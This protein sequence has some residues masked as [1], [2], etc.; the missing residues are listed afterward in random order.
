MAEFRFEVLIKEA[1]RQM[2]GKDLPEG[3][4]DWV[5]VMNCIAWN[6][7]FPGCL[8]VCYEIAR[9]NNVP[10]KEEEIKEIAEFQTYDKAARELAGKEKTGTLLS[11]AAI[12]LVDEFL[13]DGFNGLPA[14]KNEPRT[15]KGLS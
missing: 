11:D 7:A 13:A 9:L 8:Q 12:R 14:K 5:K 15:S 4:E 2:L 1:S 6:V 3:R 10:L